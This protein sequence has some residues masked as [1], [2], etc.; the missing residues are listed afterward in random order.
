MSA[1][2]ARS[3]HNWDFGAITSNMAQDIQTQLQQQVI[4]TGLIIMSTSTLGLAASSSGRF[5]VQ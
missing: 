2:S 4:D 1:E 3:I 5:V